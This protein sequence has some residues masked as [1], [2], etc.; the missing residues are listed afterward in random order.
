M[1]FA[2]STLA[3]LLSVLPTVVRVFLKGE[4][5]ITSFLCFKSFKS[6]L[7]HLENVL[8]SLAW[9]TKC[10]FLWICRFKPGPLPPLVIHSHWTG[11]D[12]FTLHQDLSFP[13]DLSYAL[14]LP[15]RNDHSP[16]FIGA[17]SMLFSQIEVWA[18]TRPPQ[19][20]HSF[21]R[22]HSKHNIGSTVNH[23]P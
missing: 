22:P 9:P 10:W 1:P 19:K 12:I 11:T 6:I 23:E 3:R 7:L 21:I 5:W 15:P 16:T 2:F 14:P 17:I 20:K 4:N 13:M 8:E 18:F